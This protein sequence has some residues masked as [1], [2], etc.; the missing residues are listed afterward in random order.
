[1]PV[2]HKVGIVDPHRAA[3]AERNTPQ[4]LTLPGNRRHS[5]GEEGA[6]GGQ[7]L[8]A[9]RVELEDGADVHGHRTTVS[10]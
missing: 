1:V 7:R 5:F 9:R 10:G 6:H 3:A 4:P 8:T 2:K